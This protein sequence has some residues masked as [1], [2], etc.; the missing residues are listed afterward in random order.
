MEPFSYKNMGQRMRRRRVEKCLSVET[1]AGMM[2]MSAET[3]KAYEYGKRRMQIET[4]VVYCRIV[5]L[6]VEK[7]LFG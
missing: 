3:V 6:P 2:H 4:L 5:D 7:V 1:L